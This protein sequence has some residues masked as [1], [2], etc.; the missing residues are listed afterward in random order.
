MVHDHGGGALL[1]DE[2][3]RRR[4]LHPERVL[5]GKE[6]EQLRMILE[7]GTRAIAPRVSLAAPRGDAELAAD[8]AMEPLGHGFR[9]LHG[10]TV[11]VE[12]LAVLARRLLALES[13]SRLVADRDDLESDDVDVAAV[14][15]AEVVGD[16]QPLASLLAGEVKACP[17]DQRSVARVR[18]RLVH[19]ELVAT[20]LRR[21]VAVRG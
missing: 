6:P 15:G 19:D 10:E 21:E 2:L 18:L 9:A 5:G 16:A 1:G 14:G 12:R 13:T 7:V 20:A 8:A 3:V 4:Q 11:L 17:L